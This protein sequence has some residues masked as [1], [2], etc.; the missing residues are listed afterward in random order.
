M[1]VA[2]NALIQVGFW[3]L[4]LAATVS[5]PAK[6]I[7]VNTANNASPGE[8]E[9]N[10]AQAILVLQD[11]DTIRFHL[12]GAGPFY[13][14]TPPTVPNNG[15]PP[16]T[17][18][19][20]TIDGYTQPGATPNTN[21][22]LASNTAAIKVVLDSRAGGGRIENIPGY[23]DHEAAVLFV[24]GATN[25]TIRGLCFLGPGVGD[26]RPENPDSYAISFALGANAGRIQGCWIGVDLDRTSVF[27]FTAG[28]TGFEGP[29][30]TVLSGT[31]LGVDKTAP[32]AL[33]ARGQFNIIVGPYV[34]VILEGQAQRIAGNFINVFPD[35]LTDYN[36][37]G[38]PPHDVQ[39][40]IEIGRR[41]DNL[42][43]GTDGDGQNDAEERNVFGGVTVA[44]DGQI[45]EWYG[46]TRTNM[47]I[48]GNYFG[49]AVDGV[50]RFTT[51]SKVF[52]D[53]PSSAR[54]RIGSDFNGVSDELEGN[55]IAMNYPF[56]TLF[57][58]P[59]KP[60]PPSFA[61]FEPGAQVSLRGNR[62]MGN[63]IVPFSYA[64][65]SDALL[66]AFTNYFAP[67]MDATKVFP[68]LSTNSN[69]LRLI[70]S[71]ALGVPP[72]T[73]VA[74]DIY[75]ADEEAWTN[76]QAFQL[77]ELAYSDPLTSATRYY[78][79]AQ[80]RTHLASFTDNGPEDLDARPGFFEFNL[81][82]FG[83]NAGALV[84]CTA[85]YSADPPGTPNGRTHTSTF[86]MPVSLWM[87]PRLAISLSGT[88]VVLSWPTNDGVFSVQSSGDVYPI[89]WSDLVPQPVL[90][91]SGTNY[92]G[93]VPV[94]GARRFYRLAR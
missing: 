67:F 41:G 12:P 81:S 22:V 60:G 68:V 51:S 75:L 61:D 45:L 56:G 29:T 34:P 43:L 82:Q 74:V 42:V 38:V 79:F 64:D 33:A 58:A 40:L 53:F 2:W 27:R 26:S 93:T 11:G 15:Y 80:G 83:L 18:H 91:V 62:L 1:K 85:N 73:N 87:A 23:S 31:V 16:I 77:S 17:N 71:C 3:L 28:V 5:A 65:G 94:A 39:A 10:L 49:V 90:N 63:N 47:I 88:N 70:G 21:T 48:A 8:G 30:G 78:G 4:A 46:G 25:V 59:A 69:Q 7:T 92:Q 55:I 89:S 57:P 76:G 24:K 84:T 36:S 19:N 20:V 54:V 44:D 52:S 14:I 72:Y 50:T 13:L 6:V 86:A 66:P 35:G 37:D 32:D 9:T